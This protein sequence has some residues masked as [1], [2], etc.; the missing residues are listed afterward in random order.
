MPHQETLQPRMYC[1]QCGHA[2]VGLSKHRCPECGTRFRP[3]DPE[4]FLL[5]PPSW[6]SKIGWDGRPS[7]LHT[8]LTIFCALCV[9]NACS[10]PYGLELVW[11][12]LIY[13]LGLVLIVRYAVGL[14]REASRREWSQMRRQAPWSRRWM[15]LPIC[16]GLSITCMVFSRQLLHLRFAASRSAFETAVGNINAGQVPSVPTWIGLYRVKHFW[17]DGGTLQFM[18]GHTAVDPC[19]FEFSPIGPQSVLGARR[20]VA[21]GWHVVEW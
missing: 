5:R 7:L 12:M 6:S 10:Q 2:L 11:M 17:I 20:Q 8:A 15:V 13:P 1:R 4:T 3:H 19:G 9:L 21:P 16:L 18:T 14:R